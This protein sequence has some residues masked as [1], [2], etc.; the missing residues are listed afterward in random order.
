MELG[1][2]LDTIFTRIPHGFQPPEQD[3]TAGESVVEFGY[4]RASTAVRIAKSSS[5]SCAVVP[6]SVNDSVSSSVQRTRIQNGTLR[7]IYNY[8]RHSSRSFYCWR[9]LLGRRVSILG[10]SSPS[11]TRCRVLH[12]ETTF[13]SFR[14]VA[15]CFHRTSPT[16]GLCQ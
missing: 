1:A 7:R 10:F 5:G 2:C 14:N 15:Q 3:R 9:S 4:F 11:D 12:G 8:S 16:L 13:N 6:E